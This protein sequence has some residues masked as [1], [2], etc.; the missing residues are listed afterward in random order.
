MEEALKERHEAAKQVQFVL[1][2]AEGVSEDTP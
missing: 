1:E 2:I